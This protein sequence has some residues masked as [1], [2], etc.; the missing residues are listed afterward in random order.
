MAKT[1]K[2][3]KLGIDIGSTTAKVV[4]FDSLDKIVFTSYQKHNTYIY[5]A[6][7]EALQKAEQQLGNITVTA[8][9]TGTAGMGVSERNNIKF[10]QEVIA[11]TDVVEKKHPDVKT[12][13]DIGGEDT[14]MIFFR[15]GKNPDIRMN[16]NCAGGTGAFIEQMATLLNVKI[17]DMNALTEKAKNHYPIASRCGVFAKTDIQNLLARKVDK[18]DIA[19]SIFH[20]VGIQTLNTLSRGYEVLPKVMF[21]GGPLTFMPEL[22][23]KM[24][25]SMHLTEEDMVLPEFSEFFPAQG[26]AMASE[27]EEPVAL[28]D[29]IQKFEASKNLKSEP[30]DR[31]P[32]LFKDSDEYN[33][34]LKNRNIITP[35]RVTLKEYT[36]KNLYLGI[37]SGSTTSKV[38]IL[39]DNNELIFSYYI[40]NGGNTLEKIH[41]GIK[42]FYTDNQD[43]IKSRNLSISASAVTGYGED[44][45]KAAMGIDYG[46]VETLAHFSAAKFLNDKVDFIMDIGGQDMKAIF[47]QNGVI[48]RIELNES[49]SA[50]CGSFIETFAKTLGLSTPEFSQEACKSAAPCDLGTR[51]TVFMNSKVKQSLR[52][53]A[54]VGDI[55]AGLAYSVIKNALFKVLKL[56][57]FDELGNTIVVQGGTFKNQAVYRAL[58]ILTGKK[59]TS[60]DIPEMMGAFGAALYAKA[61]FEAGG[62]SNSTFVGLENLDTALDYTNKQILCKGCENNCLVTSFKFNNKQTYYSGNKCQKVFNSK[63]SNT[64]KGENLFAIRYNLLFD[65]NT[66]VKNPRLTIA[67][68][69]V[70]NQ[71]SNY[72]FWHK[73]F[74]ECGIKVLL[75]PPTT[76]PM[77][78]TGAGTIMSD[79]ICFPAKIV[80]GHIMW[81]ISQK[82]DRI[83][84]PIVTYEKNEYKNT[85]NSFNCPIVSGYSDVIKSSVDT[86]N[87]YGIPFDNPVCNFNDE[88]LLYK[89]CKKYLKS[90]GISS[91]DIKRAFKSA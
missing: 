87:R 60:T 33:L 29:L 66:E 49:C 19:A 74:T 75:T 59:L 84:Y 30:K 13:V 67:I 43:I 72:P 31:L 83:F 25:A 40:S 21:I 32:Y 76:M 69:R 91:S 7:T 38:A 81:A 23:K 45:V 18:S 41:A 50:G 57:N 48:N 42:Q 85:E 35:K 52:E 3:C 63:G 70:L 11:A 78:E 44:L 26:A 20:A 55:S 15:P 65:R 64:D 73:L 58:E 47:I 2:Y 1:D 88:D 46:I 54:S 39:G 51:C 14:K 71:Y 10:I 62:V 61:N 36:G 68:P 5:Q 37:D 9:I 22:R 6:V 34:W 82:P 79:N 90:L 53:N 89:T 24:L 56:K 4:V 16:G 8:A 80:H 17:E 27:G 12:L 77:Y 86:E 28:N